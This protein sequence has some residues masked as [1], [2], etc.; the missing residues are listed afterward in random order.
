MTKKIVIRLSGGLGNQ[1]FQYAAA[2]QV[3]MRSDCALELDLSTLYRR[4]PGVTPRNF[5]LNQ[6]IREEELTHG[7]EVSKLNQFLMGNRY[8]FISSF[9][10]LTQRVF[11]ERGPDFDKRVLNVTSGWTMEGYFQSELYFQEISKTIAEEFSSPVNTSDW[12]KELCDE[13]ACDKES[14]SVHIRM[15]D[16]HHERNVPIHGVLPHKYYKD[17]FKWLR[18]STSVGK[19]YVFSDGNVEQFFEA[20]D[21]PNEIV[22]VTPPRTSPPLESL[23]AMSHASALVTANSSFSWWAAWLAHIRRSSVVLAPSPW[24]RSVAL[25]TRDLIPPTW[26]KIPHNW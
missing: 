20:P 3:A 10:Q 13:I 7:Q 4:I 15:T 8:N 1:L 16:F 12:F 5:E 18:R 25:S 14:V 19:L 9:S 2:R 21:W 22:V 17:A 23:L 24:Y 6:I 26:V 11:R